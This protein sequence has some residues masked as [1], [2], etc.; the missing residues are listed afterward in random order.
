MHDTF[1]LS[2]GPDGGFAIRKLAILLVERVVH[3]FVLKFNIGFVMHPIL[4][5]DWH[6]RG[7]APPVGRS[8]RRRPP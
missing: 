7:R 3:L 5:L 4:L 6:V 2:M 8:E 1:A